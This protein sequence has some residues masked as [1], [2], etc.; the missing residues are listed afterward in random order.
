MPSSHQI[1]TYEGELYK[2]NICTVLSI[3]L[4]GGTRGTRWQT[5]AAQQGKASF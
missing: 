2:C 4:H 1:Q 3:D 5:E